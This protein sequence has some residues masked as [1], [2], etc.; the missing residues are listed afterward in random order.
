MTS[1][2]TSV[3][4][5]IW[6]YHL[7][8]AQQKTILANC[9][10]HFPSHS[11]YLPIPI[12]QNVQHVQ[13]SNA[14]LYIIWGSMECDPVYSTIYHLTLRGWPKQGQEV[15]HIARHFWG[16]RDKLSINSGLLL[17]GTRVCIPPELLN[18][19]PADLHGAHQGINRM[20]T[21]VREAVYWPGINAD[22]A[23]YVC[24]L[25]ICTKPLPLHSQCFPE[26]YLMAPGRKLQLTMSPIRVKSIY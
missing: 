4:A 8:K 20:Q 12:A 26:M 2:N 24:Q 6:L 25:T 22:I 1:M 19:T 7:V 14:E 3:H 17:K 5:E 21:Q 16:A 23:K 15:P 18:C 13:L 10:S 9:L 11:N